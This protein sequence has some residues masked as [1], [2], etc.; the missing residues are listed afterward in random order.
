MSSQRLMVVS[1]DPSVHELLAHTLKPEDC[2]I[3]DIFDPQ[4]AVKCLRQAPCDVMVAGPGRNGFDGLKLLRKVRNL[5]PKARVILTGEP[6]PQR[7]IGALQHRAYCYF[8]SPAAP[9]PLTDMVHLALGSPSWQDE[10]RLLSARPDWLTLDVRCK[11][12]AVDRT[13]L[14]VREVEGDLPAHVREDVAAAFR[15]LM[16]NAVEHGGK[17]DPRKRVRASLVRTSR[18]LIVHIHDPGTGFSLDF[19]PHAAISNPADSPIKHVEVRAEEG[20]RPGGFGI[21]LTK[22]M[23]DELKYNERGNAV[24]FV[25]YLDGG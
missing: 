22:S 12:E 4:D 7:V 6:D 1:A 8:R 14:F 19:L 9:G 18:A 16:M 20:R 17:S 21:L 23:V 5:A 2:S 3:Q 24:L 10:I 25:K 13:T 11:M 15:E